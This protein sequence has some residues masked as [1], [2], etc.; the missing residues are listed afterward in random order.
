MNES[1]KVYQ[2]VDNDWYLRDISGT[3]EK[4]EN[5]I[6]NLCM[7]PNTG[8]LYL[9]RV[10]GKFEFDFKLYGLK[11]KLVNQV[12]KYYSSSKGNLGI[13]LN[14]VKGTG[15]TITGKV[16]A[17]NLGL[18]IIVVTG[19]ASGLSSF[20]ASINQDLVVM[21]D[22]Y[23]KIYSAESTRYNQE[24][25]E[26]EKHADASL[27]T[28]M[29]GVFTNKYR[30]TFILTTNEVWLNENMLNRP[31]RIRYKETFEDLDLETI[32]EIIDDSL[33]YTE[34]KENL[35]TFVKSLKLI[36]VDIL[37]AIIT[38]VNIFQEE[39]AICCASMNLEFLE[40]TY[41]VYEIVNEERFLLDGE[42][43]ARYYKDIVNRHKRKGKG[44]TFTANGQN[45]IFTQK[46]KEEGEPVA[47]AQWD[48]KTINKTMIFVENEP[49][50]NSFKQIKNLSLVL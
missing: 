5:E 46:F 8:E 38:E 41:S 7:N 40:K 16:I 13:L 10:G 45:Y 23:E 20:I 9:N 35:I 19:K 3:K 14:G 48:D 36:T 4:L 47:V 26:D 37:K 39:P 29:D 12:V 17:N 11:S 15:K 18:P 49:T 1:K 33:T 42:I 43:S 6:Y 31:G 44:V 34:Q 50:H 32:N 21:I 27:L 25:G 22:E 2:V 24:T 30:R 28:L